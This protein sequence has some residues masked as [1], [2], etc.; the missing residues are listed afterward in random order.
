MASHGSTV[1]LENVAAALTF[2]IDDPVGHQSWALCQ[3]LSDASFGKRPVL[4]SAVDVQRAATVFDSS[5]IP[6]VGIEQYLLR[7]FKTFRCSDA[8]F[9][10][11]LVVVDRL[12]EYEG[13]RLPLTLRNVHRI[14]FASLV[15]TVK[16]HE[17]LVYSNS[18]YAKAGGVHLKEVNR[19]EKVILA[20]LDFDLRVT[21]EEYE[22]Y[23]AALQKLSAFRGEERTIAIGECELPKVQV[24]APRIEHIIPA[25]QVKD[26][27]RSDEASS[28]PSTTISEELTVAMDLRKSTCLQTTGGEL[29]H[30]SEAAWKNTKSSLCDSSMVVHILA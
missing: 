7:L 29:Q 13:G 21:I 25:K 10:A 3:T 16:Y 28:T 20:A 19:L 14:F 4:R 1:L 24:I 26:S 17:D 30:E 9:I 5:A 11:A 8:A 22:R 23:E 12:L 15:V 27:P 18:H 6:P 2:A